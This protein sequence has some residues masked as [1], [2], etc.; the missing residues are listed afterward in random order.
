MLDS[1]PVRIYLKQ[2]DCIPMLTPREEL[3]AARNIE[4]ARR[5]FREAL[6]ETGYVLQ[7][8]KRLLERVREGKCRLDRTLEMAQ[9]DARYKARLRRQLGTN[10]ETVGHL[11]GKCREDFLAGTDPG[12]PLS[13]RREAWRELTARRRKGA[14]LV[15]EVVPQ[16]Q[17]LQSMFEQLKQVS[18]RMTVVADELAQ[19][20]PESNDGDRT[21]EL[22]VELRH[23]MRLTLDTPSLLRRRVARIERLQREHVAARRVLSTGNLRLVVSIAKRY[24]NRGVGFLD[25]IQEGNTG[26][27]RAVDKF[28]CSRG[29]KFSTYATWWIRQAVVRAIS[30]QSRTIRVPAYMNETTGRVGAVTQDLL[31]KNGY[32]PSVEQAAEA[33]GLSVEEISLAI[34]ANRHP[35][36]LDQ[37]VGYG[38]DCYFGDLLQDHRLDDPIET[39]NHDLLKSR[40]SDALTALNYRERQVIRLRYGL[41]DGHP[42]T[43]DSIGKIFSVSRE[44]IRQIETNALR[45]LQQPNRARHLMSFIEMPATA[46]FDALSVESA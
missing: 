27:M 13:W 11:L 19:L 35:L 42:Y 8:S 39:M 14:A 1:D 7:C 46:G 15:A 25:L 40:I 29:F 26:L 16:A 10:L 31:Q 20:G 18:R 28:D 17:F 9:P 37:P 30:D 44:R 21:E 36:S 38:E 12:R 33:S 32:E 3:A 22:R 34:R 23:L 2:M 5:R 41:A 45:K 4:I 43:L 6:L 24:R